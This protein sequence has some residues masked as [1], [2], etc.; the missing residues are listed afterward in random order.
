MKK[1]GFTLVE[2]LVVISIIAILLAVLMPALSKAKLQASAI[3]CLTDVKTLSTAWFMYVG[4]N[5]GKIVGAHTW[6][7]GPDS[8][9]KKKNNFNVD[10]TAVYSDSKQNLL[11]NW[12]ELPQAEDGTRKDNRPHKDHEILGIQ[13]GLLFPYVGKKIDVFHCPMDKRLLQDKK[14]DYGGYRSYSIAG[15]MDGYYFAGL[16]VVKK[17]SQ[18]PQPSYKYVFVE[19]YWKSDTDGFGWNSQAWQL[20]PTGDSWTDPL[21]VAHGNKSILGFADAHGE[22]I[23]WKDKRT[24]AYSKDKGANSEYRNQPDNPDLKFMQER[25]TVLK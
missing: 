8:K 13:R 25:W 6:L 15:C 23:R 17:H 24:I 14:R 2:L 7:S 21:S 10:A 20:N 9:A 5:N 11:T 12:V 3:I 16:R 19:E 22:A 18:I 1:S 4:D